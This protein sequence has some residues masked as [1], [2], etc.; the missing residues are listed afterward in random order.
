MPP[1]ESRAC[2]ETTMR[3]SVPPPDTPAPTPTLWT[4]LTCCFILD[5]SA[6]V[7]EVTIV[8]TGD[9]AVRATPSYCPACSETLFQIPFIASRWLLRVPL[10]CA[11]A[12]SY[13]VLYGGLPIGSVRRKSAVLNAG[14]PPLEYF[15]RFRR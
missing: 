14:W 15:S 10:E 4:A 2:A 13:R 1:A 6:I 7:T 8:I 11:W 5:A 12:G 9:P 3:R